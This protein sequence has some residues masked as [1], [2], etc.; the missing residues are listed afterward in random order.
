MDR[1]DSFAD[2][3]MP[4]HGDENMT[5]LGARVGTPLYMS[6]E[7]ARGETST[8][9][10]RSDIYSAG[11][12][13]LELLT[14]RHPLADRPHVAA[15]CAALQQEEPPSVIS[16]IWE[17]PAQPPVPSELRHFIR[18]IVRP[19]RE[20]R[21]ATVAEVIADLEAIRSGDFRVQ[22]PATFM[23]RLQRGGDRFVDAHPMIANAAALM[24]LSSVL[25]A[26]GSIIGGVLTR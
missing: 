6:P 10:A 18:R 4:G 25:Y 17:H 22:C 12:L 9:D 14:L 26:L 16:A 19:E 24:V 20:A 13:F 21:P 1:E 23:K 3:P 15:I 8:L 5:R 7:Q 11:M 2:T